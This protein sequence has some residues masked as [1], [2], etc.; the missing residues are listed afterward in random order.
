[1]NRN[2]LVV[3]GIFINAS[4][5]KIGLNSNISISNTLFTNHEHFFFVDKNKNIIVLLNDGTEY[6][7]IVKDSDKWIFK[8][9]SLAGFC[10]FS[11]NKNIEQHYTIG[12]ANLQDI[13]D[14]K[15]HKDMIS[16]GAL[17]F[18]FSRGLE[19]TSLVSESHS[20]YFIPSLF[21][22]PEE[23]YI[24][25]QLENIYL[26]RFGKIYKIIN[27][28]SKYSES[29]VP[30]LY[31]QDESTN[32]FF[33]LINEHIIGVNEESKNH[34]NAFM[35]KSDINLSIIPLKIFLIYLE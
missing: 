13:I 25:K 22:K 16:Y 3:T 2:D 18:N 5:I 6:A 20:F 21:N 8:L 15:I 31:L 9:K 29:R 10:H 30:M 34:N 24:Y 19:V 17:I 35:I 26:F 1:M 4:D 7:S 12:T 27:R 33:I 32:E 23:C 11:I 28:N 14:M